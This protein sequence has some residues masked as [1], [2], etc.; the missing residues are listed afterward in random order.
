ML[1]LIRQFL[2][3]RTNKDWGETQ[4]VT[5]DTEPSI[6]PLILAHGN[7]LVTAE[8]T[9]STWHDVTPIVN[10]DSTITL[11]RHGHIIGHV[12]HYETIGRT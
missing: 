5:V 7:Y 3:R 4:W 11:T 6:Y 2:T 10:E 9:T 8:E 1:N 12:N